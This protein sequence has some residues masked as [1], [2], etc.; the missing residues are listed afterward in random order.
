MPDRATL[1]H[2]NTPSPSRPPAIL[3]MGPTASGKSGVAQDLAGR[4]PVEIISVDSAQVYRH[5]DIGTAKPN[6]Q[7]REAFPHHLIDLVEP[8]E[9]YSAA[10]FALDALSMMRDIT[11]RGNIPLLAGGTMLYF[12]ALL[13]GLSD[14]PPRNAELRR[15]IEDQAGKIGWPGMHQ[16][17]QRIDP[18]SAARIKPADSQRIQRAL[19]VC[20]LAGKPLSE[21]LEAPRVHDLPYTVINV[22]LVPSDRG[23]LHH[24]IARRF[25]KMLALGLI[26]EVHS[27]RRRFELNETSIS[28]RCVGYRQAWMYLSGIIGAVEMREK[29]VAATR[30]LAKRQLT[31]LRGMEGPKKFDC[32]NEIPTEQIFAYITMNLEVGAAPVR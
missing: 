6:A 4:L 17:L 7:T 2:C 23:V 19:E 18:V 16:E 14:L 12:R 25:D 5:M 1:P 9:H 15:Q 8:H 21:I 10:R 22:A 29:A 30:Q 11:S 27:I 26:D 3:L 20:Y 31:W 24:R 32:A 13:E 28:M